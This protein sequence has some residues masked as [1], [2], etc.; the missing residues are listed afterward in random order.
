MK[1]KFYLIILFVLIFSPITFII[2]HE[3]VSNEQ[4]PQ[5]SSENQYESAS[6]FHP[7]I[8]LWKNSDFNTLK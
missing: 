6:N 2:S 8:H 7:Q 3:T 1:K 4:D 5:N